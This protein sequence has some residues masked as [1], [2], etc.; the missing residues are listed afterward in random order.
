MK[1]RWDLKNIDERLV[2]TLASR[3]HCHPI[4]ATVLANRGMPGLLFDTEHEARA[5]LL[6]PG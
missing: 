1:K 3:L 4:M 5:W 2:R 6:G